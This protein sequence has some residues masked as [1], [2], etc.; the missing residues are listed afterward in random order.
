M[1]RKKL[2]L[3]FLLLLA[4][5]I[6]KPNKTYAF[7]DTEKHWSAQYVDFLAEKNLVSGYK[8]GSFKSDDNITGQNF[9]K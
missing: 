1:N 8:D 9:I 3:F 5:I 4:L 6:I 7:T 2:P